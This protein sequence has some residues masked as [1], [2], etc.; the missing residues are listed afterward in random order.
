MP[1]AWTAVPVTDIRVGDRVRHRGQEFDVARI[2]QNFMGRSDMVCF[3]E[4][5]PQRWH[6]YP[7]RI[8]DDVEVYRPAT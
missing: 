3:I 6:A 7:A 5:D 4:D 2:D 1:T 8:G